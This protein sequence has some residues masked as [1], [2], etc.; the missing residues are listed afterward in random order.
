MTHK[1]KVTR[2]LENDKAEVLVRRETACG[3][4]CADCRGCRANPEAIIVVAE[5]LIHARA[6]DEVQ[7][8]CS[9]KKVLWLAAL[10]YIVPF[11]LFICG[12]LV[13]LLAGLEKPWDI[14][15]CSAG[16]LLGIGINILQH[17]KMRKKPDIT[18]RIVDLG[19]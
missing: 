15:F 9:S 16:F 2:V 3:H 11:M 10:V 18:Y 8:E 1:A 12:Y 4:S 19:N 5:N 13:A 14:V 17:R 6:G 7:L